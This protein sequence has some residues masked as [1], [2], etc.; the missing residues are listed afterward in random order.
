LQECHEMRIAT[1]KAKRAGKSGL[2][3]PLKL[4]GDRLTIGGR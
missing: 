3:Q 4:R 2:F 1:F